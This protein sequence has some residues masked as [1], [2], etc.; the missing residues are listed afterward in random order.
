MTD[1]ELLQT[2]A[3]S[4]DSTFLG[5]FLSRYQNSLVR[6]VARLLGDHHAA[7]DVVQETFLQ[8]AR[9]PKRLL[10]VNNHHNWLL[11]VARN[12]GINWIRRNQTARKHAQV[13]KERAAAQPAE[14]EAGPA[15]AL[16]NAMLTDKVMAAVNGLKP[17]NREVL[18]L[19]IQENK[20]YREIA[21]IT[22]LTATNVGFILHTTIKALSERLN[23]TRGETL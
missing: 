19:K 9:H 11:R 7:Q 4:G 22:G 21:E 18:L 1:L 17:R 5:T 20:S 15:Q 2:Y 10:T 14:A 16:D 12:L 3:Q 6:F 8:V 23:T 13:L